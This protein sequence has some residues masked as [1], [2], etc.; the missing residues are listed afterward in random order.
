MMIINVSGH[1]FSTPKKLITIKKINYIREKC[2]FLKF[3]PITKTC[4]INSKPILLS[5]YSSFKKLE[6]KGWNIR[7]NIDCLAFPFLGFKIHS[8]LF[9]FSVFV[10]VHLDLNQTIN[11]LNLI[12]EAFYYFMLTCCRMFSRC[13]QTKYNFIIRSLFTSFVM[14][15]FQRWN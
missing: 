10:F 8:W 2:I 3:C 1:V 4:W 7:L 9:F 15:F 13:W 12:Y 14:I 11:C 5:Q 6:N